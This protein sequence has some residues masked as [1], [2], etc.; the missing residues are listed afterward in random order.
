M[1][2]RSLHVFIILLYPTVVGGQSGNDVKDVI[3]QLFTTDSY[4][5]NVRPLT[6]QTQP[7]TVHMNYFLNCKYYNYILRKRSINVMQLLCKIV[8]SNISRKDTK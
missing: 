3:T 8:V 2:T 7:V 4:N 1:F 5:K 6:D